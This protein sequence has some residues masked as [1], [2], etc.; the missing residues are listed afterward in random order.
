MSPA[1]RRLVQVRLAEDIGEADHD[2][3]EMTCV[4]DPK[5]RYPLFSTF[6]FDD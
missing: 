2:S 3:S 4:S 5:S 6:S 1:E